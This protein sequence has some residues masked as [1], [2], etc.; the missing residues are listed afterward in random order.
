MKFL[1]LVTN[2]GETIRL[3]VEKIHVVEHHAGARVTMKDG[4]A[5][6]VVDGVTEILSKLE[7][8]KEGVTA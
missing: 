2:G 7:S 6:D 4:S 5:Y 3:D 1:T 8:K